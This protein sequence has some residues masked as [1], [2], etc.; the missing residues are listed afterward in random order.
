MAEDRSEVLQS[1]AYAALKPS[2]KRALHVIEDALS[3]SGDGVAISLNQFLAL[4]LCPTAARYGVKQCE[5]VG[6]VTVNTGPRR[7]HVFMM[8]DG[9][10]SISADEAARRMALARQ[11]MQ[12]AKPVKPPKLVKVPKPVPVEPPRTMRRQVPSLPRLSF[13]D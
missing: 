6:L 13:M 3:R 7:V 9:W 2:G 12:R 4:G 11:P 10:K 8:A 1:A 5:R